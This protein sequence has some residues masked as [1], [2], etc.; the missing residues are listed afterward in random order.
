MQIRIGIDATVLS[1]NREGIGNYVRQLLLAL[2]EIPHPDYHFTL[3]AYSD[4]AGQYPQLAKQYDIVMLKQPQ[5]K[6]TGVRTAY[7]ISRLAKAAKIN[8]LIS[9]HSHLLPIFFTP[10]LWV[11]HDISP[12]IHPQFF[13]SKRRS[14]KQRLLHFLFN[15]AIKGSSKILTVS[16]FS[17]TEVV[18]SFDIDANKVAVVGASWGSVIDTAVTKSRA[19]QRQTVMKEF[20]VESAHYFLSL[21]TLSPR[22]NIETILRAFAHFQQSDISGNYKLVIAGKKG[23][24]YDN[25]FD[26]YKGLLQK[27]P[28]LRDK[29]IFTGFINDTSAK[30]LLENCTAFISASHYEG[31][32]IPPLEALMYDRQVVL[33]DIPVYREIY[34]SV[35]LFFP[36]NESKELAKLLKTVVTSKEKG[37]DENARKKVLDTYSWSKVAENLL[38]NLPK[39]NKNA[40]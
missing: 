2:D 7:N 29:I 35:G 5:G 17:K 34:S 23:W 31:F 1:Y 21:G 4:F 36:T 11:I 26:T 16:K 18:D 24:N 3:F 10:T 8:A 22:K 25:I 33:S 20:G 13:G 38:A 39:K 28:A 30:V 15:A 6:L 32:G 40:E 37:A 9:T 19:S 12:I 14:F 27:Y